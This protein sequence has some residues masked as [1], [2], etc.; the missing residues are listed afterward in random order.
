MERSQLRL[1]ALAIRTNN[2]AANEVRGAVSL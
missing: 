1:L 2:G